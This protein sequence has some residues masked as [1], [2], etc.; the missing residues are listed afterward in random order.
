VSAKAPAPR[1]A[2]SR[3]DG[4]AGTLLAPVGWLWDRV[5][6]LRAAA[7]A[8]GWRPTFRPPLPTLSI[9]NLAAG[10]TG[11]TPL[12]LASIAWLERHGARVGVLSRGYGGD[13]GILLRER[14][15][16][17][18][19]IED[20]DRARGLVQ[21]LE[22]GPPEVLLLDDAFQHQRI[23]RDEDVVL[24]DATRPFGR[25]LP[26]GLFRESP[27]AL[28]RATQVV[29]SRAEL[30]GVSER[31]AIWRAV[32]AARAGL[33]PLPR[34]EG[35]VR[36]RELRELATG[37]TRPPSALR[38]MRA[39]LAAGIGNP[40]SFEALCRAAGAEPTSVQ[41]LPDHHAWT[42][43]DLAGW[44]AEPAVLVTEKDAV[45]LRGLA[46]P[47]VWEVRV[48]WEF[49]LG[50]EHWEALLGALHLPARAARFEPLWQAHDPHG[51]GAR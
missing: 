28:R 7:Y 51:R 27:S 43:A 9:G 46:G 26:A 2:A 1:G 14:H 48:D 4:P 24:L 12:L 32:D 21:L 8:R 3:L 41:W 17:T 36:V 35:G 33:P 49:G 50:G 29:L 45:K 10:G 25:C 19:L 20:P 11:K 5:A 37:A 34:I 30:V 16:E 39:R 47:G 6:R 42:A 18:L 13:E 22:L 38:G 40:S 23:E 44:D 15:P 31:S